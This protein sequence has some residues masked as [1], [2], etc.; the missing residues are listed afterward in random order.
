MNTSAQALRRKLADAHDLASVVRAMKALAA[1]S[2]G[3]YERAV[4]ALDDYERTLERALA[5][6]LRHAPQTSSDARPG[7]A[8]ASSGVIVFG[9]D[10]GLV[11]RFNEALMGRVSARLG[12]QPVAGRAGPIWAIG[13]RVQALLVEAGYRQTHLLWVPT[14]VQAITSLVDRLLVEVEA[15]RVRSDVPAVHIFYN[16]QTAAAAYAPSERR[17]LP[18]DDVWLRH[19]VAVPWPGGSPPQIIDARPG[20][21]STLIRG[22]L[23]AVL[24]RAC[25]E[26]LASE[27]ASRLAAMQRAERNIEDRLETLHRQ[28]QAMRQTAIDEEL[29]DL[30]A[31]SEALVKRHAD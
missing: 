16:R 29:F 10:Q 5:V 15:A 9:S 14:T 6:R 27:N 20:M 13:E 2:V 19:L 24:F 30:I 31:G 23:F 3:Q 28:A 7:R 25:A 11:G 18:L 1:G 22:Y 12:A 26:S 21:L 17:L 4:Q 8:M